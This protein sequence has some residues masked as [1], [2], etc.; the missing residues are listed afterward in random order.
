[1]T[2]AFQLHLQ[3]NTYQVGTWLSVQWPRGLSCARKAE[4]KAISEVAC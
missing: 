3:L 1:M 4:K 2:D